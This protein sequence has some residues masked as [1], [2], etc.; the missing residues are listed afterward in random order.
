MK[1][2]HDKSAAR[3][4]GDIADLAAF[5]GD[6]RGVTRL[7]YTD[8]D[9]AAHS[10]LA[11]LMAE[12]G[13]RVTYDAVGNLSGVWQAEADQSAVIMVGSHLDTVPQGGR[14]DGV[15]GLVVGLEAIRRLRR[16]SYR[17]ARPIELIAFRNE[18]GVRWGAGFT[19]SRAILGVL[20]PVELD[21][22]PDAEGITQAEAMRRLGIK[23]EDAPRA[24]RRPGSIFAYIEV[25]IEQGPILDSRNLP[26]GVVTGI[27]G[28]AYLNVSVFG[29]ASHAG[30]M[31][32]DLRRDALAG[33]AE[34]ILAVEDAAR[35]TRGQVVATVGKIQVS[36]GAANV[37]PGRAVFSVDY[38]SMDEAARA[39]L[40]GEIRAQAADIARRRDLSIEV[41]ATKAYAPVA[42]AEHMIDLLA[43][44]TAAIA[45]PV[46][47]LHSGAAHDA[48]NIAASAST[49]MLFVRSIGGI[50]HS[51]DELTRS[52]DLATAAA[53]LEEAVMRLTGPVQGS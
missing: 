11:D 43:A 40:A 15:A 4:E 41:T 49:G 23:P 28:P 24:A 45:V 14:F 26:V 17:P 39:R 21:G 36:P 30:A 6:G 52:D 9:A 31:P 37:V 48:T 47:R 8:A 29:Q 16:R 51:P 19:G 25:H 44:A 42:M 13:L 10:R 18:E 53:V 50:S 20:D 38:R 1:E 22:P 7:A 5:G 12:A 46:Q 34:L 27:A 35:A 2:S 33:A 32:M 3:I